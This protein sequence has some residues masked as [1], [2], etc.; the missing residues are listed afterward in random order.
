M[1]LSADAG[2][3]LRAGARSVVLGLTMATSAVAGDGFDLNGVM[4]LGFDSNPAQSRS[5]PELAFA[6]Y[7][8]DAR[9]AWSDAGGRLAL[10]GS[11][12]YRD[13]EAAND[14]YRLALGG[15]WSR[16]T[17]AGLG[18]WR[19][20]L[21]GVAYRDALVPDDERNEAALEIRYDRLLSARHSLSLNVEVR[22]LDYLNASLPWAG[23]PGSGALSGAGPAE[24][25]PAVR[26]QGAGGGRGALAVRR[27]DRLLA[28]GLDFA[29]HWS[30]DVSTRF[31]LSYADNDSPVRLE[32][33]ARPGLGARLQVKLDHAWRLDAELAWSLTR[34][35]AAPRRLTREDRQVSL[36]LAARRALGGT[37]RRGEFHC[38]LDWLDSDSTLEPYAFRQWVTQCGLSWSLR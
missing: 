19:I 33:Y 27:N 34:Y 16:E 9:R 20:G 12:W 26:G 36:G 4:A 23:R 1:N 13:Y 14:A 15:A 28:V 31:S 37:E 3:G 5:G 32:G 21:A 30:P 6:R 17:A 24:P 22:R 29:R 2:A 8:F 25:E 7:A 11:G 18:S 10:E 38:A 35:D